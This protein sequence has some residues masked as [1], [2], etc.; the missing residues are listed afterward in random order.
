M[1]VW[2]DEGKF[3]KIIDK[4]SK[5]YRIPSALIKGVIAKESAFKVRAY[6]YE[7]KIRDASFGLMQV[8]TST[9]KKLG[10]TGRKE[11]LYDPEKNIS[12]G[13]KLISENLIRAGGKINVAISA[14]NMGF[15]KERPNDA[16][17]KRDGSIWNSAYVDDV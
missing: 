4:Y 3:D 6:R 2:R 9:A 12:L 8:L 1:S 5:T 17:R 14:Y 15:S 16:A 13:A 11:K 7:P 10:F